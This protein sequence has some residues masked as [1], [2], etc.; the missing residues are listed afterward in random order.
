MRK[1]NLFRIAILLLIHANL[2]AQDDIPDFRSKRDGFLKILDTKLRAD[3][4]TFTIGGISESLTTQKLPELP[5]YYS[6]DKS[7]SFLKDTFLITITTTEFDS[8]GHKFQYYDEKYLV[9]IDNKGFWGSGTK[10]PE[11][12]IQSVTAIIGMDTIH[13]PAM[14]LADLYEPELSYEE[15]GKLKSYCR[16]YESLDKQNLYIYML[17]GAGKNRYEVTWIIQNKQYLR[18]VVDLGY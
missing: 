1:W 10:K 3:L 2:F 9:K 11:K 7:I 5:I 18:R 17:N 4:A 14:A 13:I 16:V 15:G 12:K 8:I 6:D